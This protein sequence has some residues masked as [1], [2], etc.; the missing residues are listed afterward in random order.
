MI[1]AIDAH[2]GGQHGRVIVGG[3]I[4]VLGKTMFEKKVY[5]EQHGDSLRT[6]MLR[7]PRGYP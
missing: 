7:E 4:N 6:R 1:T 5:L 2:A 3:I